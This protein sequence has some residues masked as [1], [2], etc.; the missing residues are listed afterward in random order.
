MKAAWNRLRAWFKAVSVRR[1]LEGEMA[2]E[3]RFHIEARAQDLIA[4]GL[5]PKEAARRAKV[6]FGGVATAMDGMRRSFGLRWWDELW[7]G[8]HYG[9]RVLRKS[10]GFTLIAVVSLGLA[11]GANTTIFSVANE[12]LFARLGVP[13]A[14][15]L[16]LLTV[17]ADNNSV[18][19]SSWGSFDSMPGGKTRYDSF[20]YP[21]YK[22][23]QREDRALGEIF[24]FKENFQANVTA[25]GLAE[26][27]RLEL[28]S[29]NLYEQ[30]RVQPILG[31]A[32]LPSDDEVPGAGAVAVISE[33]FWE[34]TFGRSPDVIGKVI[35]VSMRPVTIIGVN[36][37]GFTGARSVQNSPELFMPLSMIPWLKVEIGKSGPYLS[38]PN[39]WWVQLMARAKP[40]VST[41]QARAA[42][43]VEFAAAVRGTTTVKAGETIPRLV[44]E[45]GSRGLNPMGKTYAQVMYVLLAFVGLVLLL[46]CANV[47]NLMLARAR[48]RR[49]EM[50][51]R[52]AL[53]AGRRR[54][55][56]QVLTESI[57]LSALGGVLGLVLGYV[58]RSALP[59]LM[60]NAWEHDEI[61]VPFDGRV[62][63][64]TAVIV[65][66][67]GI[68]FG[69][70]PAWAATR[71]EIGLVLKEGGR[72]ATRHRKGLSGKA[73]V[74]FQ[75]A[76]STLLVVG[77]G[78]FLRT[79]I[80]LNAIDP[81]FRVEHLVL[82]DINPS[83]KE[84]P[85]TKVIAL[86]TKILDALRVIPGVD[87]VSL[88]D[89][90]LL[91]NSQ[92]NSAFYLEGSGVQVWKHGGNNPVTMV[93]TVGQEFLNVM[94]IPL[95]A[96][97]GFHPE[98]KEGTV[99]VSVVNQA[100]V[101]QFFPNQNPIGKR[102]T[103]ED[104]TEKERTWVEIIG[105]VRD[106]RYAH[107]KMDPPPLH[108]DLYRQSKAFGGAS[109]VVR[110]QLK[111]EAVTA[112]MRAALAKIDRNI[113]MM[114]V[115][116]QQQQIDAGMQQERMF[117]SLTVGFGV[118]A[119]ALACVGIYGVMAYTVSQRTNEIG[120]RLAL[121][122]ERQQVR[123]M[124]LL[125][126]GWIAGAGVAAGLG[127][128][129]ALGQ[130][131]QKLLYGLKPSDP[132]S[133]AVAGCMLMMVA[134]VATWLP[135]ARA[136]RVEPM[137]ALRH[138]G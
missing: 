115:R 89:I 136:A 106:S 59:K 51:V 47:A 69:L 113:P 7:M 111:P 32:I 112:S 76:L 94:G 87:G 13:H 72:A 117:A 55:L 134:L 118:L 35:T 17:L 77:A 66:L 81:G 24:A 26:S 15:E 31:R 14:E 92:S 119:L 36:P 96:G 20:S 120:I 33:G 39:L 91:A 25:N 138:E 48:T 104:S 75:M 34:R 63:C 52:L 109:Y 101:R 64:F 4:N 61:R 19:H 11:I 3:V 102:F 46:A 65:L 62:F 121:G 6:E 56:R 127:A 125:E 98:D 45:D 114:D 60:L 57:L 68:L 58:G 23:L 131:I 105:V 18:V 53:G 80:H 12:I 129:L 1:R 122:A 71:A 37:R 95:V 49:Q 103:M 84:Y 85:P 135:A 29:G 54:I 82:F 73:L 133:L 116:T 110:T 79:L 137:E 27:V 70:A 50:G 2:E 88:T 40:G 21:V 99:Q 90:P 78:L 128:A 42:L 9:W 22:R 126:A 30:M 97:R 124:V 44:I 67:S 43:D 107:L 130:L 86:H 100:L 93:A 8:L 41:E 10:P 5:T 132:L 108:F 28:V 16:R 83:S 38:T 74:S 123:R